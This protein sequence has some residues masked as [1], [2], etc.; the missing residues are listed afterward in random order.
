MSGCQRADGPPAPGGTTV[1]TGAPGAAGVPGGPGASTTPGGITQPVA[2]KIMGVP[3]RPEQ[4]TLARTISGLEL[5][6]RTGTDFFADQEIKFSLRF[7]PGSPPN[8]PLAGQSFSVANEF[9]SPFVHL[10]QKKPGS[11]LPASEMVSGSDYTLKVNLLEQAGS[12]IRGTVDLQIKQP[13][14][15]HLVGTFTAT[16]EPSADEPPT[17]ADAPYVTGTIAIT[18]DKAEMKCAARVFG[19]AQGKQ[20]GNSAGLPLKDGEGGWVTSSTFKP[21]LTTLVQDA[22][23]TVRYKHT[24]LPPGEYVV[25]ASWR[26]VLATWKTITVEPGSEHTVDLTI[27]PTHFGRLTIELAEGTPELENGG[28]S[29][30]IFRLL[31]VETGISFAFDPDVFRVQFDDPSEE[32]ATLPAVPPGKYRVR[33]GRYETEVEVA[34]DV[35]T[36]L[37]LGPA[38]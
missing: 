6:F 19:L 32:S 37:T 11:M 16:Y 8:A 28:L 25:G 14:D 1:A 17:A 20:I 26:G 13:P 10:S 7:D 2:G 24:V 9:A 15:S 33:W 21:Q 36:K 4:V 22:T 3:F 29:G 18:G 38:P 35:E 12:Q 5:G 31:P 27:D 23:G 30:G 34:P